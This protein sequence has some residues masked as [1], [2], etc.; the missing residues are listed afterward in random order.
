MCTGSWTAKFFTQ[1]MKEREFRKGSLLLLEQ[2]RT[3][4]ACR[5]VPTLQRT[6]EEYAKGLYL[7]VSN[8]EETGKSDSAI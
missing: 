4:E 3:S 7:S 1:R 2:V 5:M 8:L 6:A